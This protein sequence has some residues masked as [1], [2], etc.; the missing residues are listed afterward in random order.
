MVRM[1]DLHNHSLPTVDDGAKDYEEAIKNIEY[2]I[3]RGVTDIVFTS[4]YILNSRYSI[5]V[6]ERQKIL[7]RLSKM[8]NTSKINLYLGNEVFINDS[9]SDLL[10]QN[11][12]T[13]LNMS[14]YLLVEF[15]LN[16]PICHLDQFICEL[17]DQGITPII[18]HPER[19]IYFQKHPEKIEEILE[20]DCLL[21]CN[22]GSINKQFGRKAKKLMKTLLKKDLVSFIATDFHHVVSKDYITSSIKKLKKIISNEKLH[23]LCYENP[24]KV[25]ENETI[26]IH[27]YQ[28]V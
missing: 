21:Q 11:E 8:L 7:A 26:D 4:H 2:L 24:K 23:Q 28:T 6:V 5:N 19:Y 1:I 10:V 17:N 14:K 18:A 20:Y 9:I 25:L 3:E 16:H 12:I 22:L 15:P 13:T 27:R